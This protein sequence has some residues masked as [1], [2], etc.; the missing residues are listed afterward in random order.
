MPAV[1]QGLRAAGG[2]GAAGKGNPASGME[3]F[4]EEG[5]TERKEEEI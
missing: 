2:A 5:N 1:S 3:V 4:H